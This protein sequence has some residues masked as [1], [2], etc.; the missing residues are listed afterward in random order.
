MVEQEVSVRKHQSLVAGK[1]DICCRTGTLTDIDAD[2]G[3]FAQFNR[4]NTGIVNV[5]VAARAEEE[6]LNGLPLFGGDA[7][8]ILIPFNNV[9]DNLKQRNVYFVVN[10]EATMLKVGIEVDES[11]AGSC[12]FSTVDGKITEILS[13]AFILLGLNSHITKWSFGSWDMKKWGY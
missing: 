3:S 7:L 6:Q 9:L 4:I 10:P 12:K 1:V 13:I 8:I 11:G 5:Q 2:Y